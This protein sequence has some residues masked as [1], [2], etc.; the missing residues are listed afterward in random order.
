M[1]PRDVNAQSLLALG[2]L[3]IACTAPSSV[4]KLILTT[5]E[6][7]SLTERDASVC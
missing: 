5:F 7:P 6:L 4:L 2:L 1:S 3:A